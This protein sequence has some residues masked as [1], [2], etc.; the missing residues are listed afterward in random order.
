MLLT[1]VQLDDAIAGRIGHVAGRSPF[2]IAALLRWPP[3]PA[4]SPGNR[5][6]HAAAGARR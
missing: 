2:S 1:L 3:P 5:L 4:I 6:A